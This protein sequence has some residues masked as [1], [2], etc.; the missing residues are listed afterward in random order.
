MDCHNAN[1]RFNNIFHYLLSTCVRKFIEFTLSSRYLLR[2]Q[3]HFYCKSRVY[4][5]QVHKRSVTTSKNHIDPLSR[6]GSAL[7]GSY[8][9][10]LFYPPLLLP[11]FFVNA[12]GIITFSFI[13]T[14]KVLA[15]SRSRESESKFTLPKYL[16]SF[17]KIIKLS[18]MKMT[19]HLFPS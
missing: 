8:F 11:T 12:S 14:A 9:H 18:S 5:L 15:A 17:A 13:Q 16:S 19:R 7:T 10:P 2:S 6:Q 3:S 1:V 4:I